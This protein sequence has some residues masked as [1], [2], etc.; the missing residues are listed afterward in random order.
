MYDE[1]TVFFV[2]GMSTEDYFVLVQLARRKNMTR[3]QLIMD[4]L[5]QY[6]LME[7]EK[8][9]K[10]EEG[11]MMAEKAKPVK[12]QPQPEGEAEKSAGEKKK[13]EGGD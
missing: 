11:K 8:W 1:N 7:Q 6:I 10:E 2:L 3:T 5:R 4:A 12:P 13:R 9:R